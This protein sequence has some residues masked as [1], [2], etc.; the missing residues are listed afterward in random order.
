MGPHCVGPVRSSPS[1]PLES[2]HSPLPPTAWFPCSR[3]WRP[4]SPTE[5]CGGGPPSSWPALL[6]Q[7]ATTLAL[8]LLAA[9][10]TAGHWGAVV[11]LGSPGVVAMAEL[12]VDLRR[13]VF[14]P[15][16]EA[17]G[18]TPP[19]SSWT[20]STWCWPSTCRAGPGPRP[21]ATWSPGA[22]ARGCPGVLVDRPER[23][24]GAGPGA[25]R[26]RR[27]SG[28]GPGT[29]PGHLAA[30]G[31]KYRSPVVAPPTGRSAV[32][33]LW[34]PSASGAVAEAGPEE[35]RVDGAVTAGVM[36]RLVV[37]WCP[38][39]S[40]RG[41]PKGTSCEPSPGSSMAS[42]ELP[43][44]RTRRAWGLLPP[45][46]GTESVFGGEGPGRGPPGTTTA[47]I[48]AGTEVWRGGGGR[49]SVRRLLALAPT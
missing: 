43:L 45:G 48:L 33:R 15:A 32:H 4:C 26:H 18:P 21:P 8:A 22:R 20:G 5:P 31:S 39:P 30:G 42:T 9:A 47:E 34:L 7:G 12:G 14:A 13:T 35:V 49:R 27:P 24:P 29:G 44:G 11:G 19:G 25:P 1:W 2:A 17:A 38:A 3:P 37:V 10:T 41:S 36:Q 40:P 28:S 16:P 6:G 23:W 46:P